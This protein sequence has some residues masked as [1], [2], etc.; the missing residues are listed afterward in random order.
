M[1]ATMADEVVCGGNFA[2]WTV[3]HT[4]VASRIELKGWESSINIRGSGITI[5]KAKQLVSKDR[6]V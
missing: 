5:D 3:Q 4:F 2:S 6:R 1:S